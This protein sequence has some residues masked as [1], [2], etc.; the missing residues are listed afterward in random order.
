MNL[1]RRVA[2]V[3][4]PALLALTVAATASACSHGDAKT[5][6]TYYVD[7]GVGSDANNGTSAKTPWRSLSRASDAKLQPGDTLALVAGGIWRHQALEVKE[8]GTAGAPITVTRYGNAQK[9]PEVTGLDAGYCFLLRGS[10]LVL[11]RVRAVGCGYTET[12][13]YGGIGV[14]GSK[15]IVRDSY[16]AGE[17]VGVYVKDGS[18]GGLYTGNTLANNDIENVNTRGKKCGKAGASKCTDDS[19]SFAFLIHG[20]SNEFS[21]NTV[22][23]SLAKSYDWG[24]DGGAFEIFNGNRNS[25]HHNISI[26]N[27]NFSEL[28]HDAGHT[29]THNTFSYNLIRATC[30]KMCDSARGLIV[31]G[32]DSKYGPNTGTVFS[33]NTFYSNGATAR[34][35]TCHAGCSPGILTMQGNI[36]AVTGGATGAWSVWSD[37]PFAETDNVLNGPYNG[38]TKGAGTS[39]DAAQFV[40]P[41]TDLHVTASSPAVGRAGTSSFGYDLDRKPVPSNGKCPSGGSGGSGG[42]AD[43]GAYEVERHCG[44]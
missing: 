41:P 35:V 19:G 10:H 33:S 26:N 17:A 34:G 7:P 16:V 6:T 18:D 39:T 22:N 15:N 4:R 36:I 28:G 42:S 14:W 25:V 13:R 9:D 2:R 44:G 43:A 1:M 5:G 40:N 27:N 29:A 31:R 20:D 23:G 24:V 37:A 3:V 12:G 38:F 32:P 8:S 21:W 30:G 11:E